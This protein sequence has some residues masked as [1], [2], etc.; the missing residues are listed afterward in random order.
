MCLK[1]LLASFSQSYF[2]YCFDS[3]PFGCCC[4]FPLQDPL[5]SKFK[6]PQALSFMKVRDEHNEIL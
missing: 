3:S 5:E 6:Q 1:K 2:S 4:L